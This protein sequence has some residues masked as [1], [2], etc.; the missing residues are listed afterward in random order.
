LSGLRLLQMSHH[1]PFKKRVSFDFSDINLDSVLL[2]LCYASVRVC[3]RVTRQCVTSMVRSRRRSL[4]FFFLTNEIFRYHSDRNFNL[5]KVLFCVHDEW[6]YTVTFEKNYHLK[7][8]SVRT[9]QSMFCNNCY[10]TY[11]SITE[12]R[13]HDRKQ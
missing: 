7:V 4:F 5:R 9:S 13:A 8:F 2:S 10:D 12:R 6:W 1:L 11:T 3:E